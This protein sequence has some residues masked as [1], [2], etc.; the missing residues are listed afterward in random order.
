MQSIQHFQFSIIFNYKKLAQYGTD[1]RLFTNDVSANFKVR[2]T[3][4]RPNIKN[5]ASLN[6]DIVP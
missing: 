5:P 3:K 6:L 4:T 2:D 1:G